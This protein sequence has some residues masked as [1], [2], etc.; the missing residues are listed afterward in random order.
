MESLASMF[1]HGIME[2]GPDVPGSQYETKSI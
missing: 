2:S 1:Q